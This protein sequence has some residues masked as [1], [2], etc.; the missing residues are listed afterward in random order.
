M[1]AAN[2]PPPTSV[3]ES[4]APATA[5]TYLPE[6]VPL[7]A[8]PTPAVELARADLLLAVFAVALAFLTASTPAR[9]SDLWLHLATGRAL[10]D[11]SYRFHGD[12]FGQNA[13]AWVA[14]SWLYDLLSYGVYDRLG[15]GILVFLKAALAALL[16]ALLVR[17]GSRERGLAWP[18]VCTALA[19]LALC[20]RLLLQP[21]LV[22]A[23]LLAV[24]LFLLDRARRGRTARDRLS[25]L[26]AYGPICLLFAL[27][28]NL[29]DWF[30]L[31]PVT[32]ALYLLG[33]V[34][35]VIGHGS[36]RKEADLS[37]LTLLL[38][39]GLLACLVN[40]FHVRVFALPAELGL[41]A[42]AQALEQDP[43]LQGL[44][45]SPFEGAYFRAGVAWSVPGVAYLALVLFGALSFAGSRDA[46]RS[47]R[48]PVWLGLFGLS[49]WSVRAVPFFA[50]AAGPI[51]A[52]NL[53]DL[54]SRLHTV[55]PRRD[56]LLWAR[57]GRAVAM[58]LLLGLLVAAWP[59][60]LQGAP[61]EMR[62]WAVVA[63]PSVRAAAEQLALWRRDGLLG[64]NQR[65][66]HFAPE[67]ANYFAW[68]C[69]TEKGIVD[70]RLNVSAA[71][72]ADY[73]TVRRALLGHSSVRLD[74]RQ[75]LEDRQVNHLV[76]FDSNAERLQRV[77]RRLVQNENEWPLL[78][79]TGRTAVFSWVDPQHPATT[80]V[81]DVRRRLDRA[82][83]HPAE[84]EKAP[85]EWPGRG[86]QPSSWWQAFVSSRPDGSADRGEA[87]LRLVHFDALLGADR[88]EQRR[89][90][91]ASRIAAAV[92]LGGPSL[93]ARLRQVLDLFNAV[94]SFFIP[95][96]R[97]VPPVEA[98][99]LRLRGNYFLSQ[100]DAPPEL[101]W[102]AIRAARRALHA[103]PDDA[104]AYLILGEAYLR[105][106]GNTRER[107]WSNRLPFLSRL[108]GV[109]A[110]AALNQAL[111]RQPDLIAAHAALVTLYHRQGQWDLRLHHLREVLRL[112]QAQGRLPGERIAEWDERLSHLKESV[113]T[114]GEDLKR[115]QD[116]FEV[117][118]ANLSVLDRAQFA[119]EHG[120]AEKAL[121]M[122]LA[123]DV[124]SFGRK[125]ARLELSLLLTV[126]R[127]REVR[128]WMVPEQQ[129][130]LGEEDYRLLRLQLAAACGDYARADAELAALQRLIEPAIHFQTVEVS[131]RQA[132]A[133][134]L[135]KWLLDARL[136]NQSL[137]QRAA[138]LSN[139]GPLLGFIQE[140]MG[141][142][143]KG[144]DLTVLR[145]LL[146]LERGDTAEAERWFRNARDVYQMTPAPFVEGA[147]FGGNPVAHH[148]VDRLSRPQ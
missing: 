93:P 108:R 134:A 48:L 57:L 58:L 129:E 138:V 65:A 74:W 111:L 112:T 63:D 85:A 89:G 44:F 34:V 127:L 90:W 96:D 4:S 21:A 116:H 68:F 12:P 31:G 26:R 69:P 3:P 87:A 22:S 53:Q 23:V 99:P 101:L 80:S 125:G 54:T 88:A 70:A 139:R 78:L 37:G 38:G 8:P 36:D 17:L 86:P 19:V 102:L 82:A 143:R 94:V 10:A 40:P 5:V 135:G 28:A 11:G 27:W 25:W 140:L 84:N 147:G 47:W 42:T 71:E 118:A 35:S 144:A 107:V 105:L 98:G 114:L 13:T 100:D 126:G 137:V 148:F 24:T 104:H 145:G 77:Y 142:L 117:N 49:A 103:N 7:P 79:L 124:A 59:G 39:A 29:D 106:S 121:D 55:G 97:N 67:T 56:E 92:G 62:R 20:G 14:H 81:A 41:S 83:Y 52:L 119:R 133:L 109:Q 75:I 115:I 132:L 146:A 1:N 30:V 120:L 6:R 32:V 131:I 16:A 122:L 113:R 91:E 128:E 15:G 51:L 130:L 123:A 33:E 43:V 73:V 46:W 76:L 72:A 2:S 45:V 95:T 60:W 136:E 141:R 66:F 64:M 9:N 61:Y 18:A 50:V 110:S